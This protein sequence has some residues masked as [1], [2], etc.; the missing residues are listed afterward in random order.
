MTIGF[1]LCIVVS[2][3]RQRRAA[4]IQNVAY[5]PLDSYPSNT[6]VNDYKENEYTPAN[7]TIQ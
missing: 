1:I 4:H 6:I 7:A 3:K 5:M 2:N